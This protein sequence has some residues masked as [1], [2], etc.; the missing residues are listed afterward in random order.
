MKL[1]G[2]FDRNPPF[3]VIGEILI[4][5]GLATQMIVSLLYA[6]LEAKHT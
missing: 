4:R 1:K 6:V 3:L 2:P 5:I